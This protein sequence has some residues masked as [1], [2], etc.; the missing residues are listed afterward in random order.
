MGSLTRT[1]STRSFLSNV[2]FKSVEEAEMFYLHYSVAKGFNI[3]KYKLAWNSDDTV[4]IRREMVCAREGVRNKGK[5]NRVCEEDVEAGL[6]DRLIDKTKKANKQKVL[7]RSDVKDSERSCRGKKMVKP[8]NALRKV[9]FGTARAYEFLVHQAGGHE[10]VGF[11][12]RDLY[13]RVQEEN[14][15][16]MLDDV[17]G[18]LANMFWRDGQSYT[19]YCSY[20]DVLIFD[21]T[22]KTNM[23]GKPLVV[24]VGTNNHRGTVIFGYALLVDETEETYNWVLT[25]FLA[26]MKQKEHVY[27]ITDSDEAMRKALGNV[28]PEARHQLC[29]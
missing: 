8:V 1:W 4:I 12:I 22:Y 3:R 27:V 13:N 24:F 28:M 29:A 7:H 14:N 18:R 15:K 21:S 16:M 5:K 10:F 19:D 2:V 6:E 23:Y 9:S 25:A 11:T 26:S 17:K 20:R